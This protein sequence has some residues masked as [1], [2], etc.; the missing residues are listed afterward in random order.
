ME[1]PWI[2][3]RQARNA[4]PGR[5]EGAPNPPDR[6][7]AWRRTVVDEIAKP[8]SSSKIAKLPHSG[9]ARPLQQN[10]PPVPSAALCPG[11]SVAE[12]A[13]RRIAPVK[14]TAALSNSGSS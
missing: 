12:T 6:R 14:A 13:I 3:G 7:A 11:E 4:Q 9:S 1:P 8:A 2:P 5:D 10:G